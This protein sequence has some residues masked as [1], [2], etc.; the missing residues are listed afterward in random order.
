MTTVF[1]CA[2]NLVAVVIVMHLA[3][4]VQRGMGLVT[5]AWAQLEE[6]C[7][8]DC[9]IGESQ[10]LPLD[11]GSQCR[12][13]SS[14]RCEVKTC[15]LEIVWSVLESLNTHLLEI[16]RAYLILT[17]THLCQNH[18]TSHH[19]SSSILPYQAQ[20]TWCHSHVTPTDC[21]SRK[22]TGGGE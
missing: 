21:G 22:R 8:A 4:V 13:V 1:S 19:W 9:R 16:T 6:Q 11:L 5:V 18:V 20:H 15:Q 12:A 3:D 14:G 10:N 2:D 7:I 17:R